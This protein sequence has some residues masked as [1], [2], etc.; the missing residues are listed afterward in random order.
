MIEG[1]ENHDSFPEVYGKFKSVLLWYANHLMG[2]YIV[3]NYYDACIHIQET[4]N[5]G[6]TMFRMYKYNI[7]ESRP[8][9]LKYWFRFPTL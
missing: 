6:G 2:T 3:Y 5:G 1:E 4:N 7:K 9:F 8:V